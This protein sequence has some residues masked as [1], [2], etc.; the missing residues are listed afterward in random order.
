MSASGVSESMSIGRERQDVSSS[1]SSNMLTIYGVCV[2]V[3]DTQK[4]IRDVLAA[5]LVYHRGEPS[6]R[7]RQSLHSVSHRSC[8]HQST[9]MSQLQR[10]DKHHPL[11]LLVST[12][13]EDALNDVAEEVTWFTASCSSWK[14]VARYL[15]L[16][17]AY[18]LKVWLP[19]FR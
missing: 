11:L 7:R 6:E 13:P 15:H 5:E 3:P 18:H 12:V 2:R 19:F 9:I 4:R 8:I 10:A 14:A 16:R 17:L 1:P